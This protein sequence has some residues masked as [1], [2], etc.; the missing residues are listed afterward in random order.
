MK[1]LLQRVTAASVSVDGEV[2]GRIGRGLVVFVGVASGDSEEDVE[3][4]STKTVGLRIFGDEAG[5]FN[6]SVEDVGGELL[7]VSQFT[8]LASTRKGRRPGFTDAA[9]PEVAE[10]LFQRYVECV[11]AGG[12]GVATG[13]FQQYMQVEIHNDGPVTVMLDSRERHLPRNV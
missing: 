4:L 3:Y 13:R 1:A 12:L 6:L 8:L 10:R 11:A 5:K 2:V 7:V 9:P